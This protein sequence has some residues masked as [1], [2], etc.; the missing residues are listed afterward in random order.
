[1]LNTQGNFKPLLLNR[2]N[3]IMKIAI[4]LFS[5][6]VIILLAS[7][8]YYDSQEFLFPQISSTCDSTGTIP[9]ARADSVLKAN[10]MSCHDGPSSS[11]GIDL[12]TY[13]QVHSYATTLRNGT[14]I[15]QGSIR[16]MSG[17]N[18]MPLPPS[19]SLDICGMRI[20]EIWIQQGALQN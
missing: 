20:I 6:L 15:L 4:I 16:G 18:A 1:M 9:Y 3:Y 17:F 2:T 19:P 8:C 7:T 12:S 13:T 5:T 11:S 10:C 14:S